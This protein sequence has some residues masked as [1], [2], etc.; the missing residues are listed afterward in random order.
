MSNKRI[1]K[2]YVRYDGSGRVIPG[3]LILNRFKPAVG[4]W[5]EI[6]AYECCNFNFNFDVTANWS[7][8]TPAVV[9]EASFR[10]FLESGQDG[11]GNTNSLTDVIIS[12]FSLIGGRLICKLSATGSSL[13]I[14]KTE[15]SVV[16]GVGSISGIENLTLNRNQI[17]TFAPTLPL[18]K[19]LR[20]LSLNENQIVT[21]NPL[22]KLPSLLRR[23]YLDINQIVTFNPA[24]PLPNSLEELILNSNQIVTFNPTLP[25]PNSLEDLRLYNNQIVTFDPSLPLPN[26]LR[27]LEL[28]GNQI[29]TF[30][31]TL[32]LPS[33]LESLRLHNNQ[34]VIFNPTLPLPNP[35]TYFTL[36]NNQMTTAGY[37]ASEQWANA[38]TNIPGRGDVYFNDNVDSI[39][40]TT[41][42]TILISKGWTVNA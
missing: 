5:S 26:S 29:V 30:N 10:T 31:P 39:S 3:S 25:L 20:N 8:T 17:V 2:A 32:P 19:S 15:V 36:Y 22:V 34:I 24:L 12:D 14:S 21:F 40:G 23:L 37:T 38:M 33:S 13:F 42:E 4:N 6:P 18:P 1:N 16:N 9:D 41:L 11:N 28:N 35:I 7:L 27:K